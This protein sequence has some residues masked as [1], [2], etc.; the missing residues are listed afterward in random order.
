M[1]IRFLMH[2][3]YGRGGG[4]LTVVRGLAEE[5]AKRH[6]VKMVS[7]FRTRE[8]AIHRLPAG[9]DVR[10]L[11]DT[12]P[13][14]APGGMSEGAH[15][16]TSKSASQLIPAAESRSRDYSL[17]SDLVLTRY[18]ES[19]HDGVIVA[20][21]PGLSIATAK[22]ARGSAVRIAQEHR[23]FVSRPAEIKSAMLESIPRLDKF[24]TLTDRDARR[25]RRILKG[26]V[27]VGVMPNATPDFAISQSDLSN[28][29]VIGAGHLKKGKGFD[30]LVAAWEQVHQRHPDW[31]LRIFGDGDNRAKL[32]K[33]IADLHLE[34]TARLMGYTTE[35]P[36]EM[37]KASIFVLSSRVEGYPMVLMEA[38]SCGVP[39]VSFDCPTG[40]RE[41]ITPGED[42]YLVPN[43]DIDALADAIIEMIQLPDQDRKA[44][45][46]AGLRKARARSQ[47]AIA[48]RW[49]DLFSEQLAVKSQG[50]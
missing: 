46:A 11:I 22:L 49:E 2:N 50:G 15:E 6:E 42:G 44:L 21:Q 18:L 32:E 7:L 27:N 1:K 9:V 36:E 28:Q 16:R 14:A 19:V 24:L 3:V 43:H 31:E 47:S 30:R 13:G 39:V 20:M 4:V 34:G 25:Y 35:L 26:T 41:I 8:E 38:M 37:A 40:P 45:G 5:L 23:P 33:Q 29:V 10:T 12:R 48:A 17:Y